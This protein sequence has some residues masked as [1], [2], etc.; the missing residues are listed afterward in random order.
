M[1]HARIAFAGAVAI[2][3]ALARGE[4]GFPGDSSRVINPRL[5]RL[6]IAAG[7]LTLLDD[8][9]ARLAEPRVNLLELVGVLDLNAEVIEPRLAAPRGD[10]EIHP[11][12]VEHPL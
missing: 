10:R 1:G 9:A 5:L 3:G 6:R 11:G 12:I 2:G 8:V 4:K 7:G